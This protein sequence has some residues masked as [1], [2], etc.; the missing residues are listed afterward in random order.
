MNH[1]KEYS[2]HPVLNP[3]R[4]APVGVVTQNLGYFGICWNDLLHHVEG[5]LMKKS[6]DVTVI[7]VEELG[8]GWSLHPTIRV[9]VGLSF[10]LPTKGN[11]TCSVL[12][13]G[14]HSGDEEE[15]TD[16]EAGYGSAEDVR[17]LEQQHRV[18][19]SSW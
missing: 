19:P 3:Y 15:H 7:V 10:H 6:V 11:C 12:C 2:T 13:D 16:H 4:D 1:L 17:G 8:K 14:S 18:R 5:G 9:L